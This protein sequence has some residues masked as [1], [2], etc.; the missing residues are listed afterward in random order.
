MSETSQ[1]PAVLAI[2]SHVARGSV[3]NRAAVFAFE[4]F[5][6]PVW[7]VPTVLLPWHPGHGPSTRLNHDLQEFAGFMADIASAPWTSEIGAVLTG[8]MANA[9]QVR[10]VAKT[11]RELKNK[12]QSLVYVCDPVIGEKGGLYVSEETAAAI[13]DE[14]IPIGD[15]ATP[16]CFELSWLT[17]SSNAKTVSEC[18]KQINLLGS[19]SVLVTSCPGSE[20]GMTGN[21]LAGSGN[22]IA[23]WHGELDDPPN[24]PGDLTAAV[25]L[26]H[27]LEEKSLESNLKQTTAAVFE[28]L[29]RS[30][31]RG[32]DELTLESDADSL[33]NPVADIA[34]E[35]LL[36]GE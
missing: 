21:I 15:I 1:K 14:L 23:A 33:I 26:A 7:A 29:K 3:G 8:Y 11:V 19:P 4:T 30:A 22:A 6:F 18:L 35:H 28:I 10:I 31:Q 27:L 17:G 20:D 2:S 13:R 9:E 32:S 16:N 24:G 12:R 34:I 36:S 25:F 5:G